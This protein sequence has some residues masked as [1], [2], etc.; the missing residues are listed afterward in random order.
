MQWAATGCL[1]GYVRIWDLST[2][3]VRPLALAGA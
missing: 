1:G 2:F 3:H